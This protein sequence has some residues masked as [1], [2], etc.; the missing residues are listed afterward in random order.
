[1]KL[2]DLSKMHLDDIDMGGSTVSIIIFVVIALIVF[3]FA[4]KLLRWL[5]LI[6]IIAVLYFMF[7]K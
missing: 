5:V 7:A 1:M 2:P 3:R 6:G 4:K